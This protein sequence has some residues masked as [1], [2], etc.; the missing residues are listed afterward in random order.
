MVIDADVSKYFD[1]IP[2]AKLMSVVAERILDKQVLR[3]LRMW[4]KAPVVEEDANGVR[5]YVGG[6]GRRKGTPQG[7]VISP[8]LANLYLH[9]LDRI[10]QRHDLEE[11]YGARLIRYADDFVILCRGST[12]QPLEM[13]NYV[14]DR[15]DL[16]LNEDK[17]KMVNAARESF[18]FLGFEIRVR[19]SR[20]TGNYYPHVQPSRKSIKRVKDRVTAQT[21]RKLTPVPLADL[22]EGLNASLRGWAN[23]FHFRNCSAVFGE[24]KQHV[25][26]RLRTHLRKR[27]KIK[28]RGTG[29]KKYP[30]GRLYADY[31]LYKVPTT[32][33]WR[34][35]M[36]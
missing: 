8:L 31:G 28:S 14:L 16:T 23:Y 35:R 36:P 10:W 18:E 12:R 26:E 13:L 21:Q 27:H 5:R 17:T 24:V 33:G 15:L 25:E 6:K 7:G 19:Q 4:L 3:L 34:R 20:R 1:S 32:A 9:L 11:R 30:T 22:I 29:Y 2:H